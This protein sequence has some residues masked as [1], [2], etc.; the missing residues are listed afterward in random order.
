MANIDRPS[1]IAELSGV[2]EFSSVEKANQFCDSLLTVVDK[3]APL[4]LWMVITHNSTPWFESVRDE[5]L[6]AK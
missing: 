1:F 2:S 3:R 5:L 6:T 4:S